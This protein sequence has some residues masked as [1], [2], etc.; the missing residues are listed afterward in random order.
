MVTSR[1]LCK[2]NSMQNN[3]PDSAVSRTG[4]WVVPAVLWGSVG[5]LL[6]WLYGVC[7]NME[8]VAHRGR[9]AFL[10]MVGEWNGPGGE[11]AH[12]W[13]VPLV[14]VL[15]VWRQRKDLALLPRGASW[16]G[17]VVVVFSLLLYGAGMKVQQT[18][19]V[20]V[21]FVPLLWG[22]FLGV[23]GLPIARRLIF[24]CAYLLFCVPLVFIEGVTFPLRLLASYVA[25]ILLNGMGL[26]VVRIG[27]A[28]I[29]TTGGGL[30]IDVADPCSEMH[31]LMAMAALG[32]A[33]GYFT[34]R[35]Q[36]GRWLLFLGS[37]PVA[38]AGNVA[39]VVSIALVAS[40]FGQ[41]RAMVFYHDFSGYVMFGAAVMLMMGWGALLTRWIQ[42]GT[43]IHG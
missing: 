4:F 39:R 36:V 31:S 1:G 23:W 2:M 14:S 13:L 35:T 26:P 10:W 28:I 40:W 9:S 12:G 11:Y 34:Q 25:E 19:L 15:I 43:G 5:G 21:S 29:S 37:L 6:V 3:E 17:L 20:L 7:G 38:V 27:T 16:A 30:N 22:I 42:K 33:Y 32:A 18:R 24:S 41:D 8:E